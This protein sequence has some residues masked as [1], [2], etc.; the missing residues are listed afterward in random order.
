MS[1]SLGNLIELH[2]GGNLLEYLPAG[3]FSGLSRLEKLFLL[4]NNLRDIDPEAFDGLPNL[5]WMAL[6]NNLLTILPAGV[7]HKCP[8]LER[9]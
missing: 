2:M 7:F 6:N 5:L 9:M 3:S 1:C 4:S 8:K